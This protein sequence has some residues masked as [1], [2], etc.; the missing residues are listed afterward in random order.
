MSDEVGVRLESDAVPAG[1]LVRGTVHLDL[2][3]SRPVRRV[4]VRLWWAARGS[5]PRRDVVEVVGERVLVG[6]NEGG[7]EQALPFELEVP[8]GP[9]SH[10]G[11]LVQVEWTVTARVQWRRGGRD[12]LADAV[13]KV[14]P[15]PLASGRAFPR[16]HLTRLGRRQES[17]RRA[18]ASMKSAGQAGFR[19]L[20]GGV[21]VGLVASG[22]LT[23][24]D[25][26]WQAVPVAVV[27]GTTGVLAALGPPLVGWIRRLGSPRPSRVGAVPVAAFGEALTVTIR[28]RGR[29]PDRAL[30]WQ[31][32]WEEEAAKEERRPSRRGGER[33]LT[34]WHVREIRVLEGTYEGLTIRQ[35]MNLPVTLPSSGPSSL[36]T[37]WR[38]IRWVL[39]IHATGQGGTGRLDVPIVVLPV[40]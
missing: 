9:T 26:H 38:R 19:G 29:R 30:S 27:V 3:P 34:H 33:V 6:W 16:E 21:A 4:L 39:R 8:H 10:G 15:S 2:P 36:W 24:L 28:L 11:S 37:R 7:G 13:L 25:V 1:G 35:Q 31:L 5:D 14:T 40:G 17:R 20:I 18:A 12:K 23:W 22:A 32:M